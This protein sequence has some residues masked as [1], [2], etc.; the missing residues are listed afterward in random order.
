MKRILIIVPLLSA[1]QPV[2]SGVP[3]GPASLQ[4]VPPSYYSRTLRLMP[5]QREYTISQEKVRQYPHSVGEPTKLIEQQPSEQSEQLQDA[6]R[7]LDEMNEQLQ[8]LRRSITKP[9]LTNKEI[10]DRRD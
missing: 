8:K 2:Q 7:R 10:L 1:C 5:T 9:S 3:S 4:I 6:A